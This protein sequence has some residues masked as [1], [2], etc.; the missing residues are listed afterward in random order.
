MTG[1]GLVGTAAAWMNYR[2]AKAEYEA[3]QEQYEAAQ[4]AALSYQYDRYTGTNIDTKP[5][6]K[7][8]GVEYTGLLRV[9]NV[10]GKM[11]RAQ[12]SIMMTNTSKNTYYIRYAQID[13]FFDNLPV[14]I[15]KL[16]WNGLV[17]SG[18][19]Q[20][21]QNVLVDKYIKP[22]ET[23]EIKFEG[24]LSALPDEQM[25]DMRDL[26]CAVAGKELVTSITKPVSVIDGI[27]ADIKFGWTGENDSTMKDCYTLKKI[28]VLRYM[29]E[30][31]STS[32]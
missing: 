10:V 22:G 1:L 3:L 5:N 17:P 26:F 19:H 2:K 4:A 14:L 18:S 30:L 13:T 12:A 8:D 27:L 16:D 9:A 15:Y 28:G 6:D 29:R 11:F 7:P 32:E 23:L 24:G 20:V 31:S 21:P 25:A